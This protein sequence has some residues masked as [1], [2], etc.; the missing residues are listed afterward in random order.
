VMASYR[1]AP[2]FTPGAYYSVRHDGRNGPELR[3]N[4][5]HDIAITARYDITDNWLV[6][7]EGH[8]K[9]GTLDASPALNSNR[10]AVK[11]PRDWGVFL[12]KTTAYF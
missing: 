9:R 11:A 6:K 3:N 4:Y 10:L 12:A 8:F 1:V 5:Q 7:L 2:W